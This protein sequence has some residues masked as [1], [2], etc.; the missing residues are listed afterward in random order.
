[1]LPSLLKQKKNNKRFIIPAS[2]FVRPDIKVVTPAT[3]ESKTPAGYEKIDQMEV[4][5]PISVE[6]PE[7]D[8]EAEQIK[9]AKKIA[10]ERPKI[11]LNKEH[12]RTSGLSLKSIKKKKEHLIKQMD[13]I[14][15]DDELPKDSFTEP[16]MRKAWD[17]YVTRIR[18]KGKH[19]LASILQ[20]D[21]PRLKDTTIHLEFPNATN[22]VEVERQQHEILRSI[23]QEL[24]NFE[25]NLS[26]TVNEEIDKKYVYTTLEKFQKLKEKNTKIDLL[27]KTFDLDI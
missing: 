2:N 20:I 16:E 12:K 22:K 27:R 5:G 23:R 6:E 18:K 9:V 21:T 19:N 11:I 15:E 17:N 10:S 24:N 7:F 14:L 3:T 4:V 26:L 13:V 8:V 1:M 25:V